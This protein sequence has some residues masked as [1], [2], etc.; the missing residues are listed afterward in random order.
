MSKLLPNMTALV[1]I[2]LAMLALGMAAVWGC[3]RGPAVQYVEGDGD[4]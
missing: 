2:R 4:A 3:G 1:K